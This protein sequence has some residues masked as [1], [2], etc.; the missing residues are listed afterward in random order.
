[1]PVLFS[2]PAACSHIREDLVL[3]L[4]ASVLPP[5]MG[6]SSMMIAGFMQDHSSRNAHDAGNPP[7]GQEEQLGLGGS[8]VDSGGFLCVQGSEQHLPHLVS[9]K[10][11]QPLSSLRQSDKGPSRTDAVHSQQVVRSL[12]MLAH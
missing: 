11:R 2:L 6:N 12:L 10:A 7:C 9:V 5:S 8:L 4:C 3:R 1:M